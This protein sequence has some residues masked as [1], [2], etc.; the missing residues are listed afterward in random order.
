LEGAVK[1]LTAYR[2]LLGNHID[3]KET[4]IRTIKDMLKGE[5]LPTPDVIIQETARFY[6]LSVEDIRGSGR[7]RDTALA[8]QV[9]MYLTRKLTDLSLVSIGREY[10]GKSGRGMDHSSVLNS[11]TKIEELVKENPA[12]NDTIRNIQNNITDQS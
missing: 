7:T 6:G 11:I 8:R 9:S 4:V 1:K 3:D 5:F 2:E 12:F 10:K